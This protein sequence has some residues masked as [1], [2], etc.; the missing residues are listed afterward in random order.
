VD[1]EITGAE[2][3]K[4]FPTN[5]AMVVNDFLV[6]HFPDIT[7]YSFTAEIEQEF[8]EIANGKLKWQ[9]MIEQ[10]YRPFHKTVSKT[11]LVERSSVQN[12][13][14]ELG[15]DPKSGKKV[16]AKLGR[17][18][19][20]IQIGENPEDGNPEKPK[21]ASLRPGQFIENL[22]LED[23]IELMK[24]PRDLGLFEEK[25][26]VA[27]IGR[28][29]PYVLHDK[30]FV[31]IPKGEDAYTVT[32][33]R[34]V[35]LILTKREADKNKTIKLFEENPDVQVLNGRFGP[36]IKAGK[37]NVKIP[38]D[39]V[40]ADLTLEECLVLVENAP[41]RKGRFFRRKKE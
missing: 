33:E 11:E 18:G 38:K 36:Y 5:I 20:Y 35:E 37:K 17:F 15:I 9:K 26:V 2:K 7:N 19:A 29:G 32:P 25:P 27:N 31:S 40:P 39:K 23:A 3:N 12:K 1:S 16:Y 30:K 8:D 28:F 6:E 10:F 13:N 22:T 4:L 21:F 14:R 34:A 24:M 41:E